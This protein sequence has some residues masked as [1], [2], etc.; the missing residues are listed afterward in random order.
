ML[1]PHI[2]WVVTT[3]YQTFTYA[4]TSHP[5]SSAG[6]LVKGNVGYILGSVG[7]LALP[8][9]AYCL[10]VRPSRATIAEA[11]WPPDPARRLLATLFWIP[12]ALPLVVAPLLN[13]KLTS[14]W[15]MQA[16]FL[17]PILLL[18]PASAK[19][20]RRAAVA[21]AGAVAAASVAVLCAA[22]AV[23]WVKH[24]SGTNEDRAYFSG[25]GK[26]VTRLWRQTS[27]RP[28]TIAFGDQSL[29]VVFY[30]PD[31]PDT[32]P[33]FQ[34][35]TAPW[36]TPERLDREGW[37]AICAFADRRC[38]ATA[39]QQ[40]AAR[41]DAKRSEFEIV[42]RFFGKLGEPRRFVMVAVPPK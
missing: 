25:I 27:E 37:I 35:W 42:P 8:L 22:P 15:T 34:F 12:L 4:L 3:G 32:V 39:A 41:P 33:G 14:I 29:P 9:L 23:A 19:L 16:W 5:G 28:L 21:V 6:E 20:T 10:A 11:L 1:A 17:L 40:A 31:H 24:V 38:I 2:H 7:F 13:I 18:A 36:V 26:E 30:S